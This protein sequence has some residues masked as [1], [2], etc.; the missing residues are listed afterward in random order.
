MCHVYK[1]VGF[2]RGGS[3]PLFP[4][5]KVGG[6]FFIFRTTITFTYMVKNWAEKVDLDS[7]HQELSI[8]MSH[9]ILFSYRFQIP[10]SFE[11]WIQKYDRWEAY[12]LSLKLIMLT[13][14]IKGPS[15]AHPSPDVC[16]QIFVFYGTSPLGGFGPQHD[17][18]KAEGAKATQWPVM[19]LEDFP[20]CT[21]FDQKRI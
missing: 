9:D 21:S 4:P 1:N 8:D 17:N 2:V 7:T 18:S 16:L 11:I 5:K 19:W 14:K 6:N 20:K 12:R 15:K 13:A 3:W 10:F